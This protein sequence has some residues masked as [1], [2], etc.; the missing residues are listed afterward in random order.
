MTTVIDRCRCHRLASD[1][2]SIKQHE[3]EYHTKCQ[4]R[5]KIN[6][7]VEL[8]PVTMEII[9]NFSSIEEKKKLQISREKFLSVDVH[10]HE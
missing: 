8:F 6:F 7:H 1:K 10:Q 2:N 4:T 5:R 3:T 9:W